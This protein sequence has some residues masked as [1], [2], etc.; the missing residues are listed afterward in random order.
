MINCKC[1]GCKERTP[2]CHGYCD[3]YAEFLAANEQLKKKRKLDQMLRDREPYTR[4]S[5]MEKRNRKI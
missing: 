1:K 5:I 4:G 3:K 2:D